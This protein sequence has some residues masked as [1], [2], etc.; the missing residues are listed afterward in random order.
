MFDKETLLRNCT[1]E[2]FGV[3]M[4][5]KIKFLN[6]QNVETPRCD[7]LTYSGTNVVDGTEYANEAL[8]VDVKSAFTDTKIESRKVVRFERVIDASPQFMIIYVEMTHSVQQGRGEATPG[9]M[10]WG[11]S[12]FHLLKNMREW[13]IINNEGIDPNHPMGIYSSIALTELAPSQEMLNE[14]DGWPDMHLA[15][16]LKGNQDYRAIPGNFP[17][18]SEEMKQWVLSLASTYQEKTFAEILDII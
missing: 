6:V 15:K 5:Q 3:F 4:L 7:N 17:E 2:T 10:W 9:V 13:S 14:I 16:F 11:R 12:F 8:A 18:P 1:S